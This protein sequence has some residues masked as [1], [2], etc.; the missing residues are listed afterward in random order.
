MSGSVNGVAKK[1]QNVEKR[2]VYIHCYGHLVNLATS[3]CIKKS[4]VLKEALDY[5]YEII[6]LIKKSPKREAKFNKL[7]EEIGDVN[8]NVRS[9]SFTRWTVK[10]KSIKSITDNYALLIATYEQDLED[11]KSMPIEMKSRIR[12]IITIMNKYSSYFGFRLAYFVLRHTNNLAT[13]LQNRDLDAA[14]G[15]D[16]KNFL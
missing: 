1:V 11:S 5:G 13:K 14:Q 2:A 10:A 6:K 8:T 16:I 3:D 12:G 9:F 15:N 7:K 4:P